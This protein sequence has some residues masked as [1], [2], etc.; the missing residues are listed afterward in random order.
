MMAGRTGYAYCLLV[1]EKD[2][3]IWAVVMYW[4]TVLRSA[5]PNI[6]TFNHEGCSI[7]GT[8]LDVAY[9]NLLGG[10]SAKSE[11]EYLF[12]GEKENGTSESL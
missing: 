6:F 9:T 2:A 10:V 1:L 7:T 8:L 4:F 3:V 5:N 11:L 12:P